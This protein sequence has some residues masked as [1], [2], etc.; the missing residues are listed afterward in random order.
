MEIILDKNHGKAI[1]IKVNPF[2]GR[3]YFQI[4]EVWRTTEEEEWKPSKK[5][6][7]I[8]SN[9]LNDF[10]KFLETNK[11]EIISEINEANV[12]VINKS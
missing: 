1:K 11:N 4:S 5:N 7:T 6:I 9:I 12:D 10:F 2:K 3:K 8:S